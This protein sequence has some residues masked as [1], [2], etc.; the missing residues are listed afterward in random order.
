VPLGPL[1][2]VI[3]LKMAK[4]CRRGF[5]SFI[6]FCG[7]GLHNECRNENIIHQKFQHFHLL[8][9]GELIALFEK[10]LFLYTVHCSA[11]WTNVVSRPRK[12]FHRVTDFL[13]LTKHDVAMKKLSELSIV[14]G[15]L[16][17]INIINILIRMI[18]INILCLISI[19]YHIY[20]WKIVMNTIIKLCL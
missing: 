9:V 16:N 14:L 1:V 4:D 18:L 13:I 3:F 11:I 10:F 5:V 17:I 2:R 20:F 12:V 7:Y 6:H 8:S 19:W 15:K